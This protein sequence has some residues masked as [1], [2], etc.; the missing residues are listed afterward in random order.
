MQ[1]VAVQGESVRRGS[2][3]ARSPLRL[4]EGAAF[5]A[6]L[7]VEC[8][9]MALARAGGPLRRALA[10][11]AG[12]LVARRAWER[13]GF[14]RLKDYATERLGLSAREIQDLARVDAALKELPQIEAALVAGTLSWTKTRLLA[15]VATA[16]DETRWLALARKLTARGLA[17]EVRAVDVG[18]VEAGAGTSD[19]EG[20]DEQPRRAGVVIRCAPPVRARWQRVRQLARRVA[21][22]A[23][24]MWQCMEAVAAEVLSTIPL[25]TDP[26]ETEPASLADAGGATGACY[27]DSS[28]A[29]RR[30]RP[31]TANGCAAHALAGDIRTGEPTAPP[32]APELHTSLRC[33]L[34]SLLKGLE[35]ADA[36]ELDARLRRAVA[37]EQRLEAQMGPLLLQVAEGR[38]YRDRGYPNLDAYARG[39]LEISPRKLHALLRLER[40]GRRVPALRQ[41]YRSARLSWVQAHALVPVMLLAGEWPHLC[42]DWVEWARG[43]SVRR[44]EE[45]VDSALVLDETDPAAFATTGG[46]P[47][48]RPAAEDSDR[49]EDL[50]TG[51]QCRGP[52]ETTE[53][54]FTGPLEVVRLFRAVLC[55][56]R[57]HLER[58]SGRGRSARL[59]SEG[60]ALAVML[61]H[62]LEVWGWGEQRLR[63]E[64]R[65][66]ERDG[67]R[68]TVPGCSSYRNL[69]RHHLE[70]RSAGGSDDAENCTTLCAAH[71][72]RGIHAGIIRCYGSAPN[73]LRFE[74]GLR[75]DGPPLAV[76]DSGERLA[77]A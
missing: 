67:W 65:V 23:L 24:P 33:L 16:E 1:V 49:Y 74:L 6:R 50:Q 56:V 42:A 72:L 41:A 39:R 66:F 64:H 40:A 28:P 37:C 27:A 29:D 61:D 21:G 11:V 76:Y 63:K 31:E 55:T 36:F 62:A 71:H 51:A 60:E 3:P 59:P 9:L 32:P 75:P 7:D 35:S 10:A 45:D 14:V 17:R 26:A 43:V 54:F 46:L 8:Q 44:L 34:E 47:E 19:D 5:A 20:D 2:P 4:L 48:V 38:L 18:S 25:E 53:L 13:L 68:C 57:R 30:V 70:F 22:E 77:Q 52:G 69:H 73:G 12:R 15:R 58:R